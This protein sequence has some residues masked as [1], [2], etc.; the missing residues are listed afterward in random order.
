MDET[1]LYFDIPRNTTFEMS[2]VKT[3]KM[4]I[5]KSLKKPPKGKFLPGVLVLGS[6]GGSMTKSFLMNDYVQK[7]LKRRPGGFFNNKDCLF[8]MDRATSHLG[9]EI[10]DTFS[11]DTI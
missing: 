9:D 8:I 10:V 1:P 11:I 3:V 7:I 6:K 4:V 5:F 2:G